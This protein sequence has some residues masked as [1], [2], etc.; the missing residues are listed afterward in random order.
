[1]TKVE[2]LKE[3]ERKLSGLPQEDIDNRLE[4]YG[5]MIDDRVDEGKSEE[6]AIND[7]GSVDSLVEDIA[8]ETPLV[9]IVKEKITP[10]RKMTGLEIAMLILGFPLWFPLLITGLSLCLVAYILVWVVVIVCYSVELGLIGG[11]VWGLIVCFIGLCNGVSNTILF[12]SSLLA[13]GGAL[14]F[15][16]AC[17]GATRGTLEVSKKIITKIKMSFMGRGK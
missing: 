9:K 7:I 12:G 4:F 3:L 5:E 11:G 8:K 10:K 1:M 15:I 17:I 13:I 2:F 14:L 6:E 16:F